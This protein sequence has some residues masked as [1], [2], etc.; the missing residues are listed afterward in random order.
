[1]AWI[2]H[3]KRWLSIKIAGRFTNLSVTVGKQLAE[4]VS[5]GS[6]RPQFK[7]SGVSVGQIGLTPYQRSRFRAPDRRAKNLRAFRRTSHPVSFFVVYPFPGAVLNVHSMVL[8]VGA[9]RFAHGNFSGRQGWLAHPR[10]LVEYLAVLTD[11][12]PRKKALLTKFAE[13]DQLTRLELPGDD[14]LRQSAI[15]IESVTKNGTRAAVQNACAE[16]LLV[17][18][19]FYGVPNLNVRALASR[20]LRVREGGWATE[21]FGDYSPTS[22]LIRIWTRTAVRK[23]VTSFGTFLST[24]CHEFCHHLDCQRFG[25]RQ[26]PHTRGFYERAAALY[27]HA[28]GTP[29]KPLVWVRMPRNRWRIDWR[30]IRSVPNEQALLDVGASDG[31]GHSSRPR[32]IEGTESAT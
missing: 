15:S 27:H 30:R 6:L 26:T 4:S 9:E 22:G 16:F 21:L 29:R 8:C 31:Q 28:R 11:R 24:L 14:R 17:A 7:S 32:V 19:E 25:F 12:P 13:S 1:M 23:Q 20:P 2:L 10:V 18:T 5:E 3:Q